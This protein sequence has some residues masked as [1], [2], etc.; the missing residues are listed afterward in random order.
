MK[1]KKKI[2]NVKVKV[3]D[4]DM[5]SNSERKKAKNQYSNCFFLNGKYI[6][7]CVWFFIDLNTIK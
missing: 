5:D 2:N 1:K 7:V 6:C 4:I 3:I